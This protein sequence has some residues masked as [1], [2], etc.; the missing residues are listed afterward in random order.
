MSFNPKSPAGSYIV[1]ALDIDA[2]VTPLGALTPFLLWIQS[3]L[4][5][6]RKIDERTY[7]SHAGYPFIVNYI[8]PKLPPM[9]EPHRHLFLLYKQPAD[10]D[11]RKHVPQLG[12]D[13][14]EKYRKLFDLE[15]WVKEAKMGPVVAASYVYVK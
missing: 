9:G 2:P 11:Y 7:L 14:S 5:I 13:A 4:S 10:F 6:K 1:I 3:D 15:D 8:S 12:T